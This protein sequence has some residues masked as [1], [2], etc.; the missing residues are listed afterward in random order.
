M[1]SAQD[2]CWIAKVA[3]KVLR[4]NYATDNHFVTRFRRRKHR[5]PAKLSHPNIINIYDV[6]LDSAAYYLSW[7][8]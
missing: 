7:N 5:L 3:V 4:A 6:G 2:V 8:M 1:Y